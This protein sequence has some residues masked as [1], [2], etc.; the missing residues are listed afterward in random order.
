MPKK[1]L[2]TASC[3]ENGRPQRAAKA[4]AIM[5]LVRHQTLIGTFVLKRFFQIAE[6]FVH[7][8]EC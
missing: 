2:K 5:G 1:E 3:L 8:F 4:A 6:K 7:S